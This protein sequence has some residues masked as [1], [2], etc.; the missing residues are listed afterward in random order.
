MKK[1]LGLMMLIFLVGC[2]LGQNITGVYVVDRYSSPKIFRVGEIG[3]EVIKTNRGYTFTLIGLKSGQII[4]RKETKLAEW[5]KHGYKYYEFQMLPAMEIP[6]FGFTIPEVVLRLKP[7]ST[8]LD[9]FV[10]Q[11][12]E[13]D[14]IHFR[15]IWGAVER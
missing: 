7:D 12:D 14:S 2:D 5:N 1:L 13:I 10:I 11:G 8:G 4:G 3:Y 9:G 6:D 15:K